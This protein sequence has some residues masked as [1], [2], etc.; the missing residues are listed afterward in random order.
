MWYHIIPVHLPKLFCKVL[1]DHVTHQ[2]LSKKASSFNH[3][4]FH[5]SH[6]SLMIKLKNF[7]LLLVVV[8]LDWPRMRMTASSNSMSKVRNRSLDRGSIERR[9]FLTGP[10][11]QTKHRKK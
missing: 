4:E 6:K 8:R 7:H 2:L 1:V 9:R 11:N 5:L 3:L 10:L